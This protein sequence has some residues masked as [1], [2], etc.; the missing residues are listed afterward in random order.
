MEVP[1]YKFVEGTGGLMLLHELDR[2][3]SDASIRIATLNSELPTLERK[4]TKSKLLMSRRKK[5]KLVS[6]ITIFSMKY[7]YW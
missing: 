3:I 5:P 4:S 7:Q 2:M 1:Y 6:W